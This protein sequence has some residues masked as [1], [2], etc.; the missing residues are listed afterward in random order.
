MRPSRND[1][2][3]GLQQLADPRCGHEW[4][5]TARDAR[6]D[7]RYASERLAAAADQDAVRERHYRYY[8]ALAQRNGAEPALAG[9]RGNEHLA[10]LD[11][12]IENLH[13]AL[14]WAVGQ[15]SAEPALALAAALGR[16]WVRRN[17]HADAVAWSDRALNLP[18]ADA[19]PA[20]RVRVLCFK[21]RSLRWLGR[22]SDQPA[23]LAQ[24]EAIARRLGD[25]WTL[26]KALQTRA[27]SEAIA[28]HRHVADQAADEALR[29]ATIAGDRWEIATAWNAKAMAA[30]TAPELRER[31]ER[32]ASLL[33]E[34]GNQQKLQ[35]MLSSASYTALLLGSDHDA[36]EFADRAIGFARELD[37]PPSWMATQGNLGLAA[38]LTGD[39]DGARDAFREELTLC[40]ELVV[41]PLASE[42]LLGLAAVAAV[43]GDLHRA[44]RLVGGASA[45]RYG[46]PQD[47]IE[48]R[49]DAIFFAAARERVGQDAWHALLNEGAN[50]NF[51]HA[52]A[53][54][55]EES[56]A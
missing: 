30:A 22:T 15:S 51:E 33:D 27:N 8:L 11:A 29:W 38:L 41:R 13:A 47:V 55:L 21:V 17:R 35:E 53:Y 45:H 40:R 31:V 1:R 24:A 12:D 10:R 48:A 6:N 26:S 25:P 16:Y 49:L 7:S 56:K 19:H 36:R 42:G 3:P 46:S 2:R 18:D 5:Y 37:D 4:A 50:L 14:R 52:I 20:L 54:G 43:T 23:V 34:V 39:T 28:D 44:A 32:A 9:S